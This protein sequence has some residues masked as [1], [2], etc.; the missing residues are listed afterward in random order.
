[1]RTYAPLPVSFTHGEG[2]WLWGQDETRYL[3]AVAGVAVCS[4]GH[5]HPA[6]AE[7]IADQ[8]KKLI[9]VSNLYHIEEQEKLAARLTALATM[10]RVFFCN[11]GAE[12]NEAAIKLARLHGHNLGYDVPKIIVCEGSFHGRT[13]AALSATGNE[14]IQAGFAPLVEGFIRVPYNDFNAIQA[15]AKNNPDIAAILIEPVQGEGGVNIPDD[16]F[17][18]NIRALC[19]QNDY[20]MMLDEV[21]TGVG[22]TG[23]WF[24]FQHHNLT[25]DVMNLA[26]GL[27]SG[28]PIGACVANG[29]AADLFGPGNHGSTFGG[30][31]LGSRVA[32]T[33]LEIIEQQK[34][35][36]NAAKQG[37]RLVDG[38][39][40]ALGDLAGV[41]NIRGK[42][43]MIGIE[44]E[45]PCA[46]LV[47]QALQQEHLLI[48]VTAGN[49]IRLL[50]SLI[51]TEEQT[52][53]IIDKVSRLVKAFL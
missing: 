29:K 1:M 37:Q 20:L 25:P 10:E 8:A 17:L 16:D 28:F 13:L 21:Q 12:A 50:P 27:G 26:K 40:D 42:G 14:K 2:A 46:E 36:N 34:L 3:D 22:R 15:A 24:A 33:V 53:E 4:L 39:K 43:L 32:S 52:D 35:A 30:N 47:K 38:F 5:A 9:H 31:P 44:L 19:D 45:K 41:K 51:I 11:S 18:P 49:V 6:I 23:K 48:N 7:A